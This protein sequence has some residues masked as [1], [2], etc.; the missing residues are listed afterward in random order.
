L[1]FEVR[2]TGIGIPP[3]KQEKIFRA[4]E[5][6]DTSTTRKYGGT[7]L[8]LSIASRLV[9]LMGGQVRVTSAP[10]RGSTFTFTARLGLQ[11]QPGG[12]PPSTAH[13]PPVLLQRLPVLIVD[14]NATNRRILEEWLRGWQ[15]KPVTVADGLAALDA[16]WHGVACGRPYPLVLLDA[17]MPDT[18][19]LTL[20]A[21]IR[22][23]SELSATRLI[24]LTSGDRPGDPARVRD[25]HIE[26]HLLKP[27][28]QDELLETI[29]RVMGRSEEDRV[30]R[31]PAEKVTEEPPRSRVT[32]PSSRPLRV[33]VAE[34]NEFN[35]QLL[36]QL[37]VRRGHT[38]WLAGNGREALT[39]AAEGAFDLLLLDVHMPEMD[40]FQVARTIRER[41]RAAGGHLPIIALTARSRQEDRERCLAAGM[42]E[43][44]SKPVRAADLW[45]VLERRSRSPGA[46]PPA[47]VPAAE[48]AGRG[49]LD[50]SV[51][52]AACGGDADMLRKLCRSFQARLPEHLAALA[53][54]LR[55]GDA[56]RL[57]EVAHKLAGMLAVFSTAAGEA[58]L[59]LEDHA[60]HG[61][62]D[63]AR[64]LVARVEVLAA[65]LARLADHLSLESLR[66]R[67]GTD[68]G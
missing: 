4:F 53:D 34:D 65:E 20:A 21:Q 59:A 5:Q 30:T 36:E 6:E 26:A 24:L 37:L 42:D 57:R 2:D 67:T 45:A 61:R 64:P 28:P 66:Q 47:P 22:Q 17:R 19:G 13:R 29:S 39:L 8:G 48:R 38:V 52:W 63:E 49:L 7:G 14:D 40:G 9:A 43:F 11:P 31:W 12:G 50:P 44:L 51:L 25:L 60:A 15:M 46:G 56:A 1:L 41:E 27:V 68:P 54:A 16:L 3:D 10:D 35:A 55:A 62:L 32:R 23:R 58:A 33:L 18:D